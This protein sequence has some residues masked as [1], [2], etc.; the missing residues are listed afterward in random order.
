MRL[1]QLQ[2]LVE[3]YRS[4]SISLA[5]ERAHISQPA[6]SASISK[7]ED[8]LGV[9]LLK[10]TNQGVYPTE[11]GEMVIQKSLQII[12]AVEEIASITRVNSSDLG[13]D[14]S[15]AVELHVNMTY[16]PKVF[17]IFKRRYPK[18]SILQKVGES[19]N[20]LR[21]VEAGKADLGIIIQTEELLKA[22][23]ISAREVLQDTLIVLTRKDNPWAEQGTITLEAA[24]A[25]PIILFNSEYITN[26]GISGILRKYGKINVNY[27]VDTYVMLEKLLMQENCIAFVPRFVASEY[28][29]MFRGLVA[30]D[31]QNSP[32]NISIVLIWSNRHKL[33][34]TEKELIKVIR[35]VFSE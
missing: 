26:C 5:A 15:I 9:R 8:E 2:Y 31:I 35:A 7:L 33:Y 1:E 18:T 28:T 12:E 20:I 32:L 25:Q 3:I 10:R 24:M 22:K 34:A 13:G 17:S 21:D 27:R 4:K 19:N 6:L 30:L 29:N 14:I 11:T 23:D 16:M